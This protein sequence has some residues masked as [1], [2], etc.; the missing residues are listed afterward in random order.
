MKEESVDLRAMLAELRDARK[1]AE[2]AGASL[3][4]EEREIEALRA[5][6]L[7]ALR[8]ANRRGGHGAQGALR[9]EEAFNRILSTPCLSVAAGLRDCARA[10]QELAPVIEQAEANR[11][12]AEEGKA[13]RHLRD[14]AKSFA[15][16]LQRKRLGTAVSQY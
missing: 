3:R 5:A 8:N 14:F 1:L 4:E 11:S 16:M 15:A 7:A 10:A 13:A 12:G 6:S 2:R 9:L